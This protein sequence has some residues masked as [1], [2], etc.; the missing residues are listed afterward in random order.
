MDSSRNELLFKKVCLYLLPIIAPLLFIVILEDIL[1]TAKVKLFVEKNENQQILNIQQ[2]RYGTQ[3]VEEICHFV[4]RSYRDGQKL[5]LVLGDSTAAGYPDYRSNNFSSLLELS[6]NKTN[7]NFHRVENYA[8]SC[9]DSDFVRRCFEKSLK[10][11]PDMVVIYTGHNDFTNR[12]HPHAISS[13]V[14]KVPWIFDLVTYL[15]FHSRTYSLVAEFFND[16]SR[17]NGSYGINS[18]IEYQAR[19]KEVTGHLIENFQIVSGIAEENKIKLVMIVPVS[20]LTE[21]EPPPR[22]L[23]NV[24]FDTKR[25]QAMKLIS[26]GRDNLKKGKTDL[27]LFDFIKAR[28]NDPVP[29]RLTTEAYK[30]LKTNFSDRDNLLLVDFEKE[31]ETTFPDK[32]KFGCDLFGGHET[33][34]CD[35]FHLNARG[36]QLLSDFL[37]KNIQQKWPDF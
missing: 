8:S 23:N 17:P 11:R 14:Q 4:P 32:H 19:H 3:N 34:Q 15:R 13:L 30:Q 35:Q 29:S 16:K 20:N 21:F 31:L 18:E 7:Q 22:E 27:A 25:N 10:A 28:D 26:D 37:L 1:S 6:L 9:K 33:A 5:V 36:H 24:F 2:C 12:F